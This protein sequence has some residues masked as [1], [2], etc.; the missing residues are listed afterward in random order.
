MSLL[1]IANSNKGE[2]V[3][4]LLLSEPGF[5]LKGCVKKELINHLISDSGRCLIFGRA[6]DVYYCRLS[7]L[8]QNYKFGRLMSSTIFI[9]V[10]GIIHRVF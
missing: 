4:T 2:K 9:V 10:Q 3:L 8:R 5:T 6:K 7:H 1:I